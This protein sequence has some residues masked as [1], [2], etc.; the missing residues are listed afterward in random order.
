MRDPDR[1]R[2]S[3]YPKRLKT[4]RETEEDT[5]RRVLGTTETA[6]PEQPGRTEP[7]KNSMNQSMAVKM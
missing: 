5:G 7:P 1:I 4:T 6:I 2:E 3:E